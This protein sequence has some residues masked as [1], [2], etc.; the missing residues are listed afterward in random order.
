MF[1]THDIEEA[2]YLADRVIVL[3]ERP[4]KVKKELIVNLPRP[5]HQQMIAEP[6]FGSL[7]RELLDELG[8]NS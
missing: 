1:I 3:S 8:V 6:E 4:G 2:I 7:V 5:R